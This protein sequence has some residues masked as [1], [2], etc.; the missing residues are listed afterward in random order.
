VDYRPTPE[1]ASESYP[2]ILI[3]GRSLYQFNAGTMT[4]RAATRELRP[5]DVLDISPEDAERV[6]V[7]EG[8][9]LKVLSRYGS[10][11]LPAHVSATVQPGQ[12]FATFQ[13]PDVRLNN[14]TG[15]RR[16]PVG[17]P[18]YKVTSVAVQRVRHDDVTTESVRSRPDP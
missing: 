2:L 1:T 4:G 14:V 17:T 6:G 5:Q 7:A 11:I 9:P 8:E 16:D 15:P 18:E 3:T 13:Q 10:A 12:V